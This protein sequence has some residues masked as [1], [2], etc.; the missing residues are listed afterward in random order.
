MKNVL[1]SKEGDGG[2]KANVDRRKRAGSRSARRG[3][4]C[5]VRGSDGAGG[6]SRACWWPRAASTNARHPLLRPPRTW[7]IYTGP[8]NPHAGKSSHSGPIWFWL[9]CLKSPINPTPPEWAPIF[10]Y[11]PEEGLAHIQRRTEHIQTNGRAWACLLAD[12]A[13]RAQACP[14]R[15]TADGL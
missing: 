2:K 5:R 9:S 4:E 10:S 15:K 6:T 14:A 1:E 8:Q 7:S 11:W 12:R 3:E 13:F